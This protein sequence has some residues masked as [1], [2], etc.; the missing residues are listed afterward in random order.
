M[1]GLAAVSIITDWVMGFLLAEESK[2]VAQKKE[3]TRSFFGR[4]YQ[5]ID[6]SE[7]MARCITLEIGRLAEIGGWWPHA[8]SFFLRWLVGPD[9]S[10]GFFLVM[11]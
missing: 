2:S 4:D 5:T 6:T 9:D 3:S 11:S 10:S 1:E 8:G 7:E